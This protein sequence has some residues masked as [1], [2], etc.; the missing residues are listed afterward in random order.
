[1]ASVNEGGGVVE[2]PIRDI[3]EEIKRSIQSIDEKLDS[4]ANVAEVLTIRQDLDNVKK[5]VTE[6]QTAQRLSEG[7]KRWAAPLLVSIAMLVVAILALKS[8]SS[9]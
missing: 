7:W 6:L 8:G 4:K 1:M 2:Y 5:A 3:L 9:K